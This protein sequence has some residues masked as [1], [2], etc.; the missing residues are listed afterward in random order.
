M[1]LFGAHLAGDPLVLSRWADDADKLLDDVS[2]VSEETAAFVDY[3]RSAITLQTQQS[4][5][6]RK[7]LGSSLD[8]I[9]NLNTAHEIE[10]ESLMKVIQLCDFYRALG[11]NDPDTTLIQMAADWQSLYG[12]HV[13]VLSQM[14][15]VP[16]DRIQRAALDAMASLTLK[17]TQFIELSAAGGSPLLIRLNCRTQLAS[18]EYDAMW[19]LWSSASPTLTLSVKRDCLEFRLQIMPCGDDSGQL[20]RAVTAAVRPVVMP[21]NAAVADVLHDLKN[22]LIAARQAL[23]TGASSRT[24]RLVQEAKASEHLDRALAFARRLRAVSSLLDEPEEEPGT[25]IGSFMR[26]YAGGLLASLPSGISIAVESSENAAMTISLDSPSLTAVLDNLVKNAIEAMPE[27]G[28]IR[29]GWTS[30]AHY[31]LVEIS[32]TGPGLPDHVVQALASGRRIISTK[33]GGN[34]L[35]LRGVQTLLRRSGGELSTSSGSSGAT[36]WLTLPLFV[37]DGED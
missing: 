7:H 26:H 12:S 31:V 37:S 11:S 2:E 28:T 9:E 32:D 25:E 1:S 6:P 30:D 19:D 17:L 34:G 8:W 15:D 24:A 13:R 29:L 27:G 36:W 3:F 18:D 21:Y 22:Q 20:A 4:Q 35:G 16:L 5:K 33:P 23:A 10:D 14:P